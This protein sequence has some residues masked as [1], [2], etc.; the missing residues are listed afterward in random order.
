[1]SFLAGH[2]YLQ[3]QLSLIALALIF[4]EKHKHD[5]DYLIA[6]AISMKHW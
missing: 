5:F 4:V 2:V 1:M 6:E 3:G